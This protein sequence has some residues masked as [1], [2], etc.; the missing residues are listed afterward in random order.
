MYD[1][2]RRTLCWWNHGPTNI[3]SDGKRHGVWSA[4]LKPKK[5]DACLDVPY[6]MSP[7][8]RRESGGACFKV[9]PVSRITDEGLPL[10]LLLLLRWSEHRPMMQMKHSSHAGTSAGI[11]NYDIPG[12]RQS[13][14]FCDSNDDM[15][16]VSRK[17]RDITRVLISKAPLTTPF[18]GTATV[19]WH[20]DDGGRVVNSLATAAT[21]DG[22]RFEQ[23]NEFVAYLSRGDPVDDV[24][25]EF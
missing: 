2:I 1:K 3:R 20:R 9:M 24:L 13:C 25:I 12:A 11:Q 17:G 15:S 14:T 6:E 21:A 23:Q 18:L 4:R 19:V 8:G 22:A 5:A 7:A 10:L 16:A